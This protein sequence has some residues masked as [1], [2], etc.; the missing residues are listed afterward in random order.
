MITIDRATPE[1]KTIAEHNQEMIMMAYARM[2]KDSRVEYNYEHILNIVKEC[3]EIQSDHTESF[4]TRETAK[5]NAYNQIREV[6]GYGR[7]ES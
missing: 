4:F 2:E 3:E 7:G 1:D 6:L 5:V